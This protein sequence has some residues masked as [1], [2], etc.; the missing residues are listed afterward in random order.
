MQAD[1]ERCRIDD[2]EGSD[3]NDDDEAPSRRRRRPSGPQKRR[4]SFVGTAQYVSPEI[5]KGNAAHL[6]TDL[7][8]YGC[9]IYQMISGLPPFRGPTDYLIFQKVL[10]VDYEFPE[11]FD[12]NAQDLIQKLLHF[13]PRERLGA[14]DTHDEHYYSIRKHPFFKGINWKELFSIT[15]PSMTTGT[16][17]DNASDSDNLSQNDFH[18]S[19]EI[20]PGLGQRQLRRLLQQ[21]FGTAEINQ[22]RKKYD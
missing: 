21:E 19:D 15:P 10:N 17:T 9:I 6:A 13:N 5:L 12:E 14:S 4:Q 11:G 20:E 8:S 7:W 22:S 18:I 1:I 3:D 16:V 2:A